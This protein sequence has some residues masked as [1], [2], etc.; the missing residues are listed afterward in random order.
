MQCQAP[1]ARQKNAAALP[2]LR[3]P[4]VMSGSS[5]L[6]TRKKESLKQ[7]H[8]VHRSRCDKPHSGGWGG[9]R[10]L[11]TLGK[12]NG[13]SDSDIFQLATTPRDG[14]SHQEGDPGP[15]GCHPP[16]PTPAHPQPNSRPG[17]ADTYRSPAARG[18]CHAL[19]GWRTY[20]R[21]EACQT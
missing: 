11:F 21:R 17:D 18:A 14:N 6:T 5:R 10:D 2:G 9:Y 19:A 4:A 12:G 16:L 15:W 7:Q 3:E 20:K 13:K 1:G 8:P